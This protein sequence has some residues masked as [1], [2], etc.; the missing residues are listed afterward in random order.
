MPK[1]STYLILGGITI[2]IINKDYILTNIKNFLK[3]PKDILAAAQKALIFFK[4]L[5]ERVE[6]PAAIKEL[7]ESFVVNEGQ[8]T[9]AMLNTVRRDYRANLRLNYL[10]SNYPGNYSNEDVLLLLLY[11]DLR[12]NIPLAVYFVVRNEELKSLTL[13]NEP[14]SILSGPYSGEMPVWR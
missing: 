13:L 8:R 1:L 6:I 5:L 10:R 14:Y 3:Y 4:D 12:E 11:G 9:L 7:F 2:A